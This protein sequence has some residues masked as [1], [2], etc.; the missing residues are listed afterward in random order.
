MPQHHQNRLLQQHQ[1]QQLQLIQEA[2]SLFSVGD[3]YVIAYRGASGLLPEHT[4][5]AYTTAIAQGADFIEVGYVISV[6]RNAGT[7]L[8]RFILA[9]TILF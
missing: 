2:V 9:G 6:Q 7:C 1:Q 5:P 4:R 8:D 3:A